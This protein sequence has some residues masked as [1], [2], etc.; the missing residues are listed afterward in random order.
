MCD[1]RN[2]VA[3]KGWALAVTVASV[4]RI[5][6]TN[7]LLSLHPPRPAAIVTYRDILLDMSSV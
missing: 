4:K 1:G 7:L 6:S 2:T 3:V 5:T